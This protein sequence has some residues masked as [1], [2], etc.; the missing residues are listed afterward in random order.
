[1]WN[2]GSTGSRLSEVADFQPIFA[3]SASAV[4][5]SEKKS[6]TT[7]RKLTTRFL[8]SLKWSSYVAHKPP[9]GAQKRKTADF[10][11]KSH[12]A[13]RK[14]ATKFLCV[15]TV[16]DKLSYLSVRKWLVGTFLSTWKFGGY[17][18][19]P[20]QNAD[21]Q[22]IFARSASAV[23]ASEKVQLTLIGSPLRTFQWAQ[24]EH[25]T[26]SQSPRPKGGSKT[27]SVQNL[28]NKLR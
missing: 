27:Q 4:I 15:K 13:W 26:L 9:K 5:T 11:V 19:T 28:N 23:T 22:S 21:F 3:R 10:R 1:M 17:W 20:F 7:N 12:F 18:P 14:S 6:I 25:R 16:S 2:F 8:M 24:Y